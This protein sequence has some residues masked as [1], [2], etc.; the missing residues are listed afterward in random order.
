MMTL[1][2][3]L[4]TWNRDQRQPPFS[5]TALS[6]F[7]R[8]CQAPRASLLRRFLTALMNSMAAPAV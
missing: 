7:S 5:L 3:I 2:T 1:T 6:R 8:R 4:T